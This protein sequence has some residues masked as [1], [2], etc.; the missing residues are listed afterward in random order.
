MIRS[1]EK[2]RGDRRLKYGCSLVEAR[3]HICTSSDLVKSTHP[4]TIF[5]VPQLLYDSLRATEEDGGGGGTSFS[6]RAASALSL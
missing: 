6:N 1:R 2:G 5:P 3:A 4:R